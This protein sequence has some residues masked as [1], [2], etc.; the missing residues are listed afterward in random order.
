MEVANGN[1][2]IGLVDA[3]SMQNYME[4]AENASLSVYKILDL[5]SGFGIVLSG[6]IARLAT[7]FQSFVTAKESTISKFVEEQVGTLT[8]SVF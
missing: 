1:A 3:T 5:Q 8:V 2:E 7:D 4:E 6:E